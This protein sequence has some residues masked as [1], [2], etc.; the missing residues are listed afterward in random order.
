MLETLSFSYPALNAGQ[1]IRTGTSE[2]QYVFKGEA[3]AA[4]PDTYMIGIKAVFAFSLATC[5]LMMLIAL[6]I[7]LSRL[8]DHAAEKGEGVEL[9]S[10]V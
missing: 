2:I 7:P 9:E 3:L 4:V 6:V 10:S 5:A 1:V 8:D